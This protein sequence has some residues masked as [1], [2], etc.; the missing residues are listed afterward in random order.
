MS[1]VTVENL[2]KVYKNAFKLDNISFGVER[3]SICAIIGD[4]VSGKTQLLEI[5]AGIKFAQQGIVDIPGDKVRYV[6]ADAVRYDVTAQELFRHTKKIY[7]LSGEEDWQC[8]CEEFG[9]DYRRRLLDMTYLENRCA[10]MI[11]SLI[12][13]PE[14]L[15]LDEPYR[16]LSEKIYLKL[17]DLIKKR[18]SEEMTAIV[19]CSRYS[20]I[21]GYADQYIYLHEG[22]LLKSGYVND[23]F[24]LCKMV[25]VFSSSFKNLEE[26]NI[27][28]VVK[29]S[30]SISFI[31]KED[32]KNLLSILEKIGC[33]DFLVEELTLEEQLFE[34]YERW[35]D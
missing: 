23:D 11:N 3:G 9:V 34:N 24:K 25:T 15:I 2:V 17:L 6:P 31:Y 26:F 33:T 13:Y 1:I 22:D 28:P 4:S 12:S 29:K 30:K 16:Y 19:S 35:R 14:V 32:S 10:A 27:V 7:G 21:E 20:N 8:L 5:L 18:C